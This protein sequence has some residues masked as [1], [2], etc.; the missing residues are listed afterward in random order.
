MNI[1]K[2]QIVQTVGTEFFGSMNWLRGKMLDGEQVAT[3]IGRFVAWTAPIR[4][5]RRRGDSAGGQ[6]SNETENRIE[7]K[8]LSSTFLGDQV[9]GRGLDCESARRG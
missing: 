2:V 5:R 3:E 4:Q 1:Q 6:A 8:V 7:G 9:E